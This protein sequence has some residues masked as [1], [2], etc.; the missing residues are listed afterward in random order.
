M[1]GDGRRRP[2]YRR[3]AG[4]NHGCIR[5]T[6]GE[7][8]REPIVLGHQWYRFP[9]GNGYRALC[10]RGSCVVR[11]WISRPESVN[12]CRVFVGAGVGTPR[13]PQPTQRR[14]FGGACRWREHD[15]AAAHSSR[16]LGEQAAVARRPLS[17]WRRERERLCAR[18]RGRCCGAQ[19]T[20]RRPRSGRS[21]VR[22]DSRQCGQQRWRQQRCDGSAEP[23]RAGGIASRRAAR[24]GRARVTAWLCG[25][26][27]H[28]HAGRRS[29]GSERAGHGACRRSSGRRAEDVD[30][31]REDQLWPHRGGSRRGRADQGGVDGAARHDSAQSALHDAESRRRVGRSAARR[32]DDA[33]AVAVTRWETVRRC[34]LLRHRRDECARRP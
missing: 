28:R 20:R 24:R 10:G 9:D 11:I 12:R 7:R 25:S 32:G 29:S 2:G 19:A 6:V 5:R 1:G 16:L 34:E 15:P 8:F 33:D 4:V 22:G 23:H 30:R 14:L 21:R 26:A 18:G 27:R 3:P 31:I 13:G 17:I